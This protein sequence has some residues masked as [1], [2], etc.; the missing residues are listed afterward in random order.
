M[1]AGRLLAATGTGATSV[2]SA[3]FLVRSVGLAPAEVGTGLLLANVAGFAALPL[4]GRCADR[5]GGRAVAA[6]LGLVAAAAL[7]WFSAVDSLIVFAAVEGVVNVALLGM[8]VG[9]RTLVAHLFE[10]RTRVRYQAYQR[11][12]TNLGMAVGALVAVLPLQADTR[13]A[14]IAVFY[15]NAVAV[16]VAAACVWFGPRPQWQ[17]TAGRPSRW[18]AF[19]DSSYLVMTVLCG[20]LVARASMLTTA[21]PL[22]I[23]MDG[24]LPRGLAGVLLAVNTGLCV[25]LQVRL[26]AKADTLPGARRS[27]WRGG[28]VF[29]LAFLAIGVAPAASAVPATGLL[30]L[31]VVA[32]S[33]A[34]ML[35]SAASWTLSFELADPAAHGQYQAVYSLGTGLGGV[36]GPPLATGVAIGLGMLGWVVAALF[37][38]VCSASAAYLIPWAARRAPS[39]ATAHADTS[40]TGSRK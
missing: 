38:L 20:V 10:G 17:G 13:D 35:T 36:V 37:F 24:D 31:G 11:S 29:V 15:A 32:F 30:L 7:P 39:A 19:S 27:M 16:A 2:C 18:A 1:L 4:V 21:I 3:L 6:V 28:Y 22:W 12:A 26:A 9:V 5:W 23:G 14:Y 40:T 34:E 8:M 33:V 25:L